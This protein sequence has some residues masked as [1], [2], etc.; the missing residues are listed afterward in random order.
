MCR[1]SWRPVFFFG[2]GESPPKK[3]ATPPPPNKKTNFPV[4]YVDNDFQQCFPPPPPQM[5][6]I[7]HQKAKTCRK[8]WCVYRP[9]YMH[10][11]YRS[12]YIKMY[13]IETHRSL[14][15]ILPNYDHGRIGT[16]WLRGGRGVDLPE[17]LHM[18]FFFL[19]CPNLGGQ[20]PPPPPPAP[21]P[22]PRTPM[23]MTTL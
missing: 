5:Y 9:S 7:P 11:I 13:Y 19:F 20:L 15:L 14:S 2:G 21:A 8:P 1:A 12:K 10:A 3:L 22:L 17:I 4:K 6:P 16:L 18:I 23:I